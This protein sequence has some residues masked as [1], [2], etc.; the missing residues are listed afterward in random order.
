MVTQVPTPVL[1]TSQSESTPSDSV[2]D[3]SFS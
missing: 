3:E 1:C 2:K